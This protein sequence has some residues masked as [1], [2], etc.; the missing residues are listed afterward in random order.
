MEVMSDVELEQTQ[1]SAVSSLSEASCNVDKRRFGFSV[2]FACSS[3]R[4]SFWRAGLNNSL[5]HEIQ[6]DFIRSRNITHILQ[7]IA[8]RANRYEF[9]QF[10]KISVKFWQVVIKVSSKI[11]TNSEIIWTLRKN[12]M[13]TQGFDDFFPKMTIWVC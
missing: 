3:S 6:N 11:E 13:N 12:R 9:Q 8:A 1:R 5:S 2:P 7:D 4:R 10:L